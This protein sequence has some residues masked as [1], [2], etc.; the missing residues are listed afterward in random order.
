MINIGRPG[1][2]GRCPIEHDD[3][4]SVMLRVAL[5]LIRQDYANR[6]LD[7]R[8]DPVMAMGDLSRWLSVS[9]FHTLVAHVGLVR[10]YVIDGV[11]VAD[12][13]DTHKALT[14][15]RVP[16]RGGSRGGRR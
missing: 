11:R 4:A 13:Y 7:Y 6:E 1:R 9:G 5:A 16:A 15:P 3:Y 12:I 14:A 8:D 10:H 2:L